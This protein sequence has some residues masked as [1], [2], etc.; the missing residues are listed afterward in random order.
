MGVLGHEGAE[1]RMK[2]KELC[3][4]PFLGNLTLPLRISLL[5]RDLRVGVLEGSGGGDGE[6]EAEEDRPVDIVMVVVTVVVGGGVDVVVD[7]GKGEEVGR[8]EEGE[9]G[10]E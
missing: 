6:G 3:S 1:R 10:D 2:T 4:S 8:G 7:E 5:K 9:G